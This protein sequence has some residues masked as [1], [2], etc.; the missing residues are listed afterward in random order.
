[1][2]KQYTY[3]LIDAAII[4]FPLVLSFDKKVA[5]YKLWKHIWLP[6]LA[7][8]LFFIIWDILFTQHGVWFFNGEYIIGCKIAGLPIEEWL[9]F[10]VVP[11]ACVFIYECL[12]C[13]FPFR[14]KPDKGWKI[15]V[16][17]SIILIAT[18]CAFYDKAYTFYTFV[19]CGLTIFFCYRL[20]NRIKTFRAD[21]FLIGFCISIIPFFIVNGILTSLPV[22]IYNDAENLG[23]RM[24]TIPFEDTFYGMLLMLGN[25][26]GM[27]WGRA[28][29]KDKM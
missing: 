23:I 24:Y 11:Y 26:V 15:L 12:L 25:I 3:L 13:Y 28:N 19:F 16:P 17:L 7:T 6:M 9:F 10:L 2:D 1:M 22:V 27:E 29:A 5:Y 21:F 18:G 14:Q 20:R 8:G 4:F